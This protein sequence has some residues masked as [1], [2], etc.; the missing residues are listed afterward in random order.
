MRTGGMRK[1]GRPERA[2]RLIPADRILSKPFSFLLLVP[3][4]SLIVYL[5]YYFH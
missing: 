1:T 4:L 2:R 5:P 3:F